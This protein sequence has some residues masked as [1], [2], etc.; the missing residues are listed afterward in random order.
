[1]KKEI[2]VAQNN[3]VEGL[4]A[5]AI[6]A[7]ASIDTLERLLA[8]RDKWMKDK[9]REAFVSAMGSF[10]AACPVIKKTRQVMN[11][12][13]RSVRYTFAPI[14]SI[15]I[16][17]KKPL[18]DAGLSYRWEVKNEGGK[19]PV[20]CIVTHVLGHSE[21]STFDV[22]TD[23]GG[24]MTAPQKVAS[25]LTFAKRYSMINVLG[26]ATSDEDTDATDVNKEPQAKSEK[27]KIVFL[28]R[29]LGRKHTTKEEIAAEVKDAT[30]LTL[31]EKNYEAIVDM[32][33]VLVGEKNADTVIE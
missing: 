8:M 2:A 1:M 27:A 32:L 20:T 29:S 9:A 22:P 16:Q 6:T 17:I 28:L 14:D 33:E 25:A 13:G 24:F 4:I 7:G 5:Q 19:M 10:Q 18:K 26:I 11:K 21:S 15:V 31:E 23:D 12:D 30:K 3:S